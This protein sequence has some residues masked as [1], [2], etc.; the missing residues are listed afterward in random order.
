VKTISK[1][2]VTTILAASLLSGC[3]TQGMGGSDVGTKQGVGALGGAILGGLAGSRFGGGTGKLV[4]VGAGTLLGAFVGSELGKSLDRADQNAMTNAAYQSY[5]APVGQTIQWNNPDSGN[6]GTFTTLRDG[7]DQSGAYCREYQQTITV[8]GRM[9][10]GHGI[11]CQQP[12]GSW[13]I[14]S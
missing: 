13:K 10:Q 9:E 12:D 2:L 8:G 3:A 6:R 1:T 11:A 14:V 7:R 4:A 5:A